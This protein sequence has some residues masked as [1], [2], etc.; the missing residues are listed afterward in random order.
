MRSII[1]ISINYVLQFKILFLTIDSM[2]D[3][4][5]MSILQ[6]FVISFSIKITIELFNL[7]LLIFN[8][9]E[10][11][12]TSF[13]FYLLSHQLQLVT[14]SSDCCYAALNDSYFSF[15]TDFILLS[16]ISLNLILYF[17]FF[18]SL[19]FHESHLW[20]FVLTSWQIH[21]SCRK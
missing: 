11:F 17:L 21:C 4:F 10:V 1:I 18:M 9:C 19:I 12:C 14:N 13:S 2:S 15:F 3:L 16:L 5:W 7:F 6:L 8:I 20:V